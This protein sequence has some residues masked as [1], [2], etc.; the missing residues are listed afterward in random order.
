[1]AVPEQVAFTYEPKWPRIED[2]DLDRVVFSYDEDEDKLILHLFGQAVPAV[3]VL[4]GRY[5]YVRVDPE[6]SQVVGIYV[7]QFL[8]RAVF[9]EPSLLSIAS[10][11]GVGDD[12]IQEIRREMPQTRL[13]AAAIQSFLPPRQRDSG[14]AVIA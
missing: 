10:L 1:V 5:G 9:E 14:S 12:R 13:K 7:E 2:L 6:T 8:S 11:V 4:S 3:S